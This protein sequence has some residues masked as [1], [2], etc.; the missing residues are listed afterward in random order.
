MM[1][2]FIKNIYCSY[3]VAIQ[4]RVRVSNRVSVLGM[5]FDPNRCS[6]RVWVLGA[7]TGAEGLLWPT[8]ARAIPKAQRNF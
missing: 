3:Y 5:D 7:Q 4:K 1:Y 6:D 8:M 2:T